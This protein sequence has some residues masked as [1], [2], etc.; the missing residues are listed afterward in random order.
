MGTGELVGKRSSRL[1]DPSLVLADADGALTSILERKPQA[2]EGYSALKY[3]YATE[4]RAYYSIAAMTRRQ[5]LENEIRDYALGKLF[6]LRSALE[7][8]IISDLE[9]C[10]LR[11]DLVDSWATRSFFGVS[12]KQGVS[13]RY[14]LASC[15]PTRTCGGRCYAHDGRDREIHRIFRGALN[16]F[17]GQTYG[18]VGTSEK[19]GLFE[20][21]KPVISY[22]VSAARQDKLESF[23]KLG[24]DRTPRIRFSH[25]GEMAA[26]PEFTNDLAREIRRV[27]PEI[28]CT[29]YTRHPNAA[30]LDAKALVIN[31]TLEGET[32]AR[33]DWVPAG[34]RVV[35]SAWDGQL[36]ASA[37]VNFL[38]HHVE[39]VRTSTGA[40]V[41][42]P[43]TADHGSI[44]SCDGA[45]CQLCFV[46]P[47]SSSRLDAP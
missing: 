41:I 26:T 27:D 15:V 40:G 36:V 31:F 32:D 39:K 35:A 34:A 19:E 38:E 46:P 25:V 18:R 24:F 22:G 8:A 7:G 23:S 29:I 30:L 45:R 5:V 12:A 28:A 14:A 37:A 44:T 43:V 6:R 20:R 13:V 4:C 47:A 33:R 2:I 3:R 1:R 11:E 42:C 9:V 21:L 10:G 16:L 17:M